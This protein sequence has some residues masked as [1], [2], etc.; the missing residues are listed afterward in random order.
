MQSHEH[1]A[2]IGISS[3]RTGWAVVSQVRSEAGR[4]VGTIIRPE[5]NGRGWEGLAKLMG[6]RLN[7]VQLVD[8]QT[9]FNYLEHCKSAAQHN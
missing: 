6:V 8:L 4:V 7:S 5:A 1:C 2:H 9:G 3:C